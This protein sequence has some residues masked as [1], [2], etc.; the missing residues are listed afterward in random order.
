M[1]PTTAMNMG[2]NW[3]GTAAATTTKLPL[4]IPALP[5]PAI[6]RPTI[7]VNEFL[8]TPQSSDPT[9]KK[10]RAARYVCLTGNIMKVL[11]K[12]G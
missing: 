5:K 4:V 3:R 9:S 12:S 1:R 8:A 2:R 10:S 7:K 11:P 6:A